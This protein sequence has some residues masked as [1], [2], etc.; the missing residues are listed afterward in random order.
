RFPGMHVY[1]YAPYERSA[2][3]RLMGE[4]GTHEHELD[5]LLRG[6]VLV[7]LYR[8]TRQALRLSLESYSIKQVEAFYSFERAEELGGGGAA[9][10]C[11]TWLEAREGAILESIRAYNEDDCRSLYELHR[12]LLELR[13]AGL[14]W[15]KPPEAREVREETQARLEERARVEAELMDRG[16]E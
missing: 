12:W 16:Q 1:H 6:E 8:V 7:D 4:H 2:L 9:V 13:P 10:S 15:R 3:Q 5:E 11:E 14:G